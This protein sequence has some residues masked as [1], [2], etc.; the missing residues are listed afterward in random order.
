MMLPGDPGNLL[1]ISGVDSVSCDL[2]VMVPH[3]GVH[4][5]LQPTGPGHQSLAP[6]TCHHHH[7]EQ[8]YHGE[9]SLDLWYYM[10]KV[11]Q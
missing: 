11:T 7:H 4:H 6:H 10:V 3:Q 1:L 8:Q 2:V 5:H 9:L